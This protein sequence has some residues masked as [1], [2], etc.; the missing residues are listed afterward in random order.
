MKVVGLEHLVVSDTY[1]ITVG[2]LDPSN[3]KMICP[4]ADH[5]NTYLKISCSYCSSQ[6]HTFYLYLTRGIYKYVI[7]IVCSALQYFCI[8]KL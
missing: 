7:D 8:R 2:K 6:I 4:P 5:V 3:S 1:S